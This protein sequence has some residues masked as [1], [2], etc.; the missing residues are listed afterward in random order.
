MSE[1]VIIILGMHRS[2]TSCLIGLLEQAGIFLGSVSRKN[3]YNI[4]GNHENPR[5]MNLHDELLTVNGGSWHEPPKVVIWPKELKNIRDEIIKE[6]EKFAGKTCWGFK[7]PRTLFTLEGWTEALSSFDLVGIYRNPLLVA[8]SL[9]RRNKF[10]IEKGL[11][12]WFRYNERLFFYFTKYQFPIVSFDS[13][14]FKEKFLQLINH[15]GLPKT[16]QFLNF[17]EPSLRHS[18]PP[19]EKPLS[20]KLSELYMK[21]EEISL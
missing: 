14:P 2:G 18:S 10:P 6:Y 11:D 5:I 15:L 9:F 21:L 13:E 4:R 12:L 17:Y 1:K 3:R 8:E 19:A 7:D 16:G 20:R